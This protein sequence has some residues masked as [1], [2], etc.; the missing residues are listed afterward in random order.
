MTAYSVVVF[1]FLLPIVP[2]FQQE[3]KKA[4][5]KETV[6]IKKKKKKKLSLHIKMT[7]QPK[8]TEQGVGRRVRCKSI[9]SGV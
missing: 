7:Q 9:W 6:D 2:A 4:V 5:V 1:F 8:T 3:G